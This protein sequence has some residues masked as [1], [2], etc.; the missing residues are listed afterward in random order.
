MCDSLESVLVTARG[1]LMVTLPAAQLAFAQRLQMVTDRSVPLLC[2]GQPFLN[3]ILP[4][5]FPFTKTFCI[6]LMSLI[7][8]N[9]DSQPTAASK[10][11]RGGGGGNDSSA[12]DD[13]EVSPL[14][15]SVPF[16]T[17]AQLELGK[18]LQGVAADTLVATY[19]LRRRLQQQLNQAK[20]AAGG[21]AGGEHC[22]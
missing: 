11:K 3:L 19:A 10:I 6:L 5:C 17:L 12:I 21:S 9:I 4:Y 2:T 22:C 15:S 8:G 1:A 20:R 7:T 14:L 18:E 13:E 16:D